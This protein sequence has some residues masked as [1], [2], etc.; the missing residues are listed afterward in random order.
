MLYDVLDKRNR[1]KILPKN[2]GFIHF[3][4]GLKLKT[5]HDSMH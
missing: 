3:L 5:M 4:Y 2:S 1:M